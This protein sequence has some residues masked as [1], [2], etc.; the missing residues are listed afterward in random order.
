[1]ERNGKPI[2]LDKLPTNE[3]KIYLPYSLVLPLHPKPAP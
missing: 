2:A 3:D 1:M